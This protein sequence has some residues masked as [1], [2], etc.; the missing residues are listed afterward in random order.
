MQA[1]DYDN[2]EKLARDAVELAEAS[3]AGPD[4]PQRVSAIS[5]L[6]EV[7]RAEGQVEQAEELLS[8]TIA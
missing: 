7:R 4:S 1:K 3:A 5:E 6:A 8:G 2:A